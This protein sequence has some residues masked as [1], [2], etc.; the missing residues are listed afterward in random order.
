MARAACSP[1]SFSGM[2]PPPIAAGVSNNL[3][4]NNPG[5]CGKQNESS[6]GVNQQDGERWRTCMWA[7]F[8]DDGRVAGLA[9]RC[10]LVGQRICGQ[11][12]N[13]LDLPEQRQSALWTHQNHAADDRR[14]TRNSD[15]GGL[16]GALDDARARWGK[17]RVSTIRPSKQTLASA[18]PRRVFRLASWSGQVGWSAARLHAAG[19]GTPVRI[20]VLALP[21]GI[22]PLSPP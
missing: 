19:E 17:V 18:S 15:P 22:E 20:K 14:Q 3:V 16:G 10:L 5:K 12:R 4:A 2:V 13:A 9:K 21:S 8:P 1:S 6:S 11:R 7:A